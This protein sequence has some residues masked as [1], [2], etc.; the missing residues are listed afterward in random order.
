M[1]SIGHSVNSCSSCMVR[2]QPCFHGQKVSFKTVMSSMR[3]V[4]GQASRM[5]SDFD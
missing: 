4:P 5:L 1:I 3:Q 2:E